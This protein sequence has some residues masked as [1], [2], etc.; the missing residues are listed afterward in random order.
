M[1]KYSSYAD[2]KLSK[3]NV[4][5]SKSPKAVNSPTYKRAFALDMPVMLL[6]KDS[7]PI[8]ATTKYSA[9]YLQRKK[10]YSSKKDGKESAKENQV[11]N[12]IDNHLGK[13][14]TLTPNNK[15][16][17]SKQKKIF[18]KEPSNKKEKVQLEL[19]E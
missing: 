11:V 4:Y 15:K 6:S 8:P 12:I 16:E 14:K 3:Y 18:K 10:I 1:K 13:E 17:S 5:D 9:G 2:L 19:K 7:F